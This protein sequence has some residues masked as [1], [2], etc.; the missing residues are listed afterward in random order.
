MIRSFNYPPALG[1]PITTQ[2]CAGVFFLIHRLSSNRISQHPCVH[3]AILQRLHF[4]WLIR[5]IIHV[6]AIV[7][8]ASPIAPA[9]AHPRKHKG[10]GILNPSITR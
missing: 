5:Q 8:T 10:H 3:A 4:S 2:L 7:K 1:V 6:A 9:V